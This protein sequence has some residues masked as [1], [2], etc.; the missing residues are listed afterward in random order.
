MMCS[1]F[2]F[3]MVCIVFFL[4]E[5]VESFTTHALERSQSHRT[6][7]FLHT[8]GIEKIDTDSISHVDLKYMEFTS[9]DESVENQREPVILLHG[10]LGQK[11][12]FASIGSAIALQ[13]EHKRRIFALDL[14]NHG[15][16]TDWRQERSYTHLA[17]DVRQFMDNAGIEKA[18]LI[19][20][21]SALVFSVESVQCFLNHV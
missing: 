10:L 14:R 13:L 2:S 16:N 8:Q 6:K 19:G 9:I 4:L 20:Y 7:M 11:R 5:N 17:G 21:V 1:F 12:N 18:V 15:D 3:P